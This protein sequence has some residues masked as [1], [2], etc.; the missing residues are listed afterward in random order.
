MAEPVV[1]TAIFETEKFVLYVHYEPGPDGAI[2]IVAAEI[3]EKPVT[4]FEERERTRTFKT[5]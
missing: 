1:F 4:P 5:K 3:V 2:F